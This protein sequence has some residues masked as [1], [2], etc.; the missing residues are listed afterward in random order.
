MNL[1]YLDIESTG[2]EIGKHEPVQVA[3]ILESN[4]EV[5][6]EFD[7]YAKPM[8]NHRTQEALDIIR[9]TWDKLQSFPHPSEL[10]QKVY[11]IV[12]KSKLNEKIHIVGHNVSFDY[13]MFKTL[14]DKYKTSNM[15]EFNE[16]FDYKS[17]DTQ[18]IALFNKYNG[19]C[20]LKHFSLE[21]VAGY[22]KI[23]PDGNFH[24]ALTDAKVTR[25]LYL[26]LT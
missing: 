12:L 19:K 11:S 10:I 21:S 20:N 5:L 6:T 3:G 8:T 1:L 14:W 2:L 9:H 22:Y 24:N 18:S 4:R 25:E 13:G 17:I 16:L 7:L 23:K 26:K 15:P